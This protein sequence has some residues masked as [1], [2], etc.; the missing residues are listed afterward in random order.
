MT[1]GSP[2]NLAASVRQR[3]QNLARARGEEFQLVLGRYALERL[4]YRLSLS[5][6]RDDF[7]LKGAMLFQLWADQPHRPTRD[8]DLLGSGGHSVPRLQ[9]VFRDVCRQLVEPDGLMFL[10]DT[11][12]GE[13]IKTDREYEGIRIQFA[14]RLDHAHIPIQV[15]IGFGDAITP[16]P[17]QLQYPS[18]L[19]FPTPTV[20]I[21]PKETVVAEKYQAMVMLGMANSRMKDFFDLWV[22][23]RTFAFDGRSLCR[24]VEATFSRRKTPL[25]VEAPLALTSEFG[26]D[27]AKVNQWAAF[28]KRAKLDVGGLTLDEICS[29]L[30]GFLMALTDALVAGESFDKNWSP[31]GPWAAR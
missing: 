9:K 10:P 15:D 29:A 30:S 7:V 20:A 5:P 14:A 25:P 17:S 19:G 27:V 26:A 23:S 12:A 24:A 2:K 1:K 13:V 8:L 18:M 16:A 22:L 28:L 4:L 31:A 21:Y 11:V 3:L 6:Y